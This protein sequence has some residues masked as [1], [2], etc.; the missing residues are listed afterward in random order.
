MIDVINFICNEIK[1]AKNNKTAFI[2]KKFLNKTP[3]W[4]SFLNCIFDEVQR[5]KTFDSFNPDAQ[6]MAFGNVLIIDGY[7]FA[8]QLN[9]WSKYFPE[10]GDVI[11]AMNRKNMMV[12]FAGPKIALG[13]RL[14]GAHQDSW[15]GFTIQCEGSTT[16]TIKYKESG[17][18][19]IF[20]LFPGDF[21]YFPQDCTHE[22]VS[23]NARA[24]LIFNIPSDHLLSGLIK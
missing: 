4:N 5:N 9:D 21:L 1:I 16:W 13:P 6:E 14:V 24:N 12:S 7:Y 3:S 17:Y 10:M 18:E 23:S 19:E 2:Y 15:D 22:I 20:E 8:P 11:N